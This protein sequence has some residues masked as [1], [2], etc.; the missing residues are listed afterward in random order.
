[1]G[2][3]GL[4]AGY[5]HERIIKAL[6]AGAR[7]VADIEVAV[8]DQISGDGLLNTLRRMERSNW[9]VFNQRGIFVTHIGKLDCLPPQTNGQPPK[10]A[11]S[12]Y[13]P[14]PAP[15]RREGSDY[16]IY[17]SVTSPGQLREYRAHV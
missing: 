8:K 17:P 14:P 15:P 16:S 4:G 5:V 11:Q 2:T 12:T 9:I 3:R 7:S 6:M 13:V 1:M 10:W